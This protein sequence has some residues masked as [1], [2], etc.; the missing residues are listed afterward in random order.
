MRNLTQISFE[1]AITQNKEAIFRICRIYAV[2]P[3]EPEDLS[4]EVIF[5]VW[6]SFD[7]CQGKSNLKTWIYRVSLNVCMSSKLKHEKKQTVRLDGVSFLESEENNDEQ[8]SRFLALKHCIETL[9]EAD[10]SVVILFLE[11]LPYA[12]IAK[13]TG[14]TVNHVAVKMKRIRKK[15]FG[16]ITAKLEEL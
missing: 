12:E 3:L 10:R 8:S 16:C 5:Q 15:L 2:A 4:Q 7:S 11:E 13:V 14:L 6:K 9:P 1:E